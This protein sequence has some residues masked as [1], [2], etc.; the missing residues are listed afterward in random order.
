[1]CFDHDGDFADFCGTAYPK[2][3]K[4]H[5]CDECDRIIEAGHLAMNQS[6]KFDGSMFSTYTC[7][8]CELT[9]YQIHLHELEEGCKGQETWCPHGELLQYCFDTKFPRADFLAGQEYLTTKRAEA[10]EQRRLAKA[11]GK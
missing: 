5:R 10:R 6:G 1:M 7:G 2:V 3:A 4:P 9:R 8:E 11:S